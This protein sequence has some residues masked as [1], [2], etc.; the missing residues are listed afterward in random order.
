MNMASLNSALS[1]ASAFAREDGDDFLAKSSTSGR[2]LRD[3]R[4]NAPV[5][6]VDRCDEHRTPHPA[7]AVD[8]FVPPLCRRRNHRGGTNRRASAD[9]RGW[10][11]LG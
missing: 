11:H 4:L 2:A 7:G 5:R 3:R 1:R 6:G 10:Y 9:R 8:N